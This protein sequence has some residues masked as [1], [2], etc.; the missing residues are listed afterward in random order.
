MTLK[1]YTPAVSPKTSI[2]RQA[3]K[4]KSSRKKIS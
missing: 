1:H 3:H 4:F 2:L